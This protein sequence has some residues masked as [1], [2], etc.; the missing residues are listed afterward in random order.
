MGLL[1]FNGCSLLYCT[2]VM[3]RIDSVRRKFT[4]FKLYIF[5]VT[6]RD[7]NVSKQNIVTAYI[8]MN[9]YKMKNCVIVILNLVLLVLLRQK[10]LNRRV[11][12]EQAEKCDYGSNK[13]L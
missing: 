10:R 7:D 3:L 12:R 9:F 8:N 13:R 6:S 5:H 2:I 1:T 4:A 11:C